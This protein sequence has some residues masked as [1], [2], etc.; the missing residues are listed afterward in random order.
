MALTETQKN[1]IRAGVVADWNA[2]APFGVPFRSY[3]RY[4]YEKLRL[5]WGTKERLVASGEGKLVGT[6]G[7]ETVAQGQATVE[8]HLSEQIVRQVSVGR[9]ANVKSL[10]LYLGRVSDE[11]TLTLPVNGTQVVATRKDNQSFGPEAQ[12]GR[13]LKVSVRETLPTSTG[14][15]VVTA[16][17]TGD[18]ALL[19]GQPEET[20]KQPA[21]P[22]A[23]L[24]Y[25]T[26]TEFDVGQGTAAM[27]TYTG[28]G[29]MRLTDTAANFGS[30]GMALRQG[31]YVELIG[32]PATSVSAVDQAAGWFYV[33]AVGVQQLQLRTVKYDR[34]AEG[35]F[36]ASTGTQPSNLND[37]F[38]YR[39]VRVESDLFT[40]ANPADAMAYAEPGDWVRARYN[41]GA[42][43]VL[44]TYKVKRRIQA[45]LIE[46][47]RDIYSG[48]QAPYTDTNADENTYVS[49]VAEYSVAK[50]TPDVMTYL[51]IT[52]PA[53]QFMTDGMVAD[54]YVLLKARTAV[55]DPSTQQ[56]KGAYPF[57]YRI[58]SV[59]QTQLTLLP[60]KH[61]LQNGKFVSV[62]SFYN[63]INDPVSYELYKTSTAYPV[64]LDGVKQRFY[65]ILSVGANGAVLN[66]KSGTKVEK[67]AADPADV[68]LGFA[69]TELEDAG[70]AIPAT[71]TE[72]VDA[73]IVRLVTDDNGRLLLVDQAA[74]F[75]QQ[76]TVGDMLDA[77]KR[78]GETQS[79]EAPGLYRINEIASPR[80]VF[81]ERARYGGPLAAPN[82]KEPPYTRKTGDAVQGYFATNP[83]NYLVKRQLLA[84]GQ[85]V[86]ER[87]Q[88]T[89]PV[90]TVAQV[91]DW[92]HVDT[93]TD[94]ARGLWRVEAVNL[95]ATN[96]VILTL[97]RDK[98][99]HNAD[100]GII[101]LAADSFPAEPF[102]ET[103]LDI[104]L[105]R[106][107]PYIEQLD[108]LVASLPESPIPWEPTVDGFA[109]RDMLKVTWAY[110]P[111]GAAEPET[112]TDYFAIS[113]YANNL[114]SLDLVPYSGA[115]GVYVRG[116]DT[117]ATG[118]AHHNASC[119]IIRVVDTLEEAQVALD[120]LVEL[121]DTA[122]T[123][124]IQDF[125]TMDQV[126]TDLIPAADNGF[127]DINVMYG[128]LAEALALTVGYKDDEH[129]VWGIDPKVTVK[130]SV[131]LAAMPPKHPT[132]ATADWRLAM[133]T[134]HF[135]QC[136]MLLASYDFR[137]IM[138]GK[139]YKE[140]KDIY[141]DVVLRSRGYEALTQATPTGVP[142]SSLASQVTE[143]LAA[144]TMTNRLRQAAEQ[145]LIARE[146]PDLVTSFDQLIDRHVD[147]AFEALT[148]NGELMANPY[149]VFVRD[150]QPQGPKPLVFNI[151]GLSIGRFYD[152]S[153]AAKR[154]AIKG[155]VGVPPD[156]TVRS[157]QRSYAL[158]RNAQRHYEDWAA[159]AQQ[160]A[161]AAT[162]P[163][164]QA[165]LAAWASRFLATAAIAEGKATNDG[166]QL[167][168]QKQA[169]LE[170][171]ENIIPD[172]AK[173]LFDNLAQLVEPASAAIE[174]S[175]EF[176]S[177]VETD[178]APTVITSGT[179]LAAGGVASEDAKLPA[180]ASF[181]GSGITNRFSNDVHDFRKTHVVQP[182]YMLQND[183][184]EDRELLSY[185]FRVSDSNS[186]I[187]GFELSKSGTLDSGPFNH[188][189]M[190][191]VQETYG[192]KYQVMDTLSRGWVAF[193]FGAQPEIWSVSGV[194]INDV[195]S[196]QATKMRE[197]Y[198]S[199][200]RI[201]MLA[202]RGEKL[203][204]AI[205][206]SGLLVY[207]YGVG[208]TMATDASSNEAVVPFTLQ[209][210]VAHV[211]FV[212]LIQHSQKFPAAVA[213]AGLIDGSPAGGGG[214]KFERPKS[215]A[216][217]PADPL[218]RPPAR[219]PVLNLDKAIPLKAPI[220]PKPN[221]GDA[222]PNTGV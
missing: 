105:V 87:V 196:D 92:L 43:V 187:K 133:A 62:G 126:L 210:L 214:L 211:Y 68:A 94:S 90:G 140:L 163:D 3:G 5:E 51:R 53:G 193:A 145:A 192:E 15:Q 37:P 144:R 110:W 194:L 142:A 82:D 149:Q 33:E 148:V 12:V 101:S 186:E 217:N 26:K 208:L 16:G 166:E 200:L 180:V 40:L 159:H 216:G 150:M 165:Q 156:R 96:K 56:A 116:G 115:D 112:R 86:Y 31:D 61:T 72:I 28:T 69:A 125:N 209:F 11:V 83:C 195:L 91:D 132:P 131:L 44:R 203:A 30:G 222:I 81:L 153:A 218:N 179:S 189:M 13:F 8:S 70:S 6:L 108:L 19:E 23:A 172:D 204:I 35:Q 71:F 50:A 89:L 134:H 124:T 171:A 47:E 17:A 202:K 10:A 21:T 57:A 151:P 207:G 76:V 48:I 199:Y 59:T 104:R 85:P 79:N 190:T 66:L 128:A 60:I 77:A 114:I 93:G 220:L 168:A 174:L 138:L 88:A 54:D 123:D 205:P 191:G 100:T 95:D 146:R 167:S 183:V 135:Q 9:M 182:L 107:E 219:S 99:N 184:L 75:D 45:G 176:V 49:R 162:K 109:L 34:Q 120:K 84:A 52:D 39:V 173:A 164:L 206:G 201:T 188:F 139:T 130:P 38:D 98:Y 143:A 129:E 58:A 161:G 185:M 106:P 157:K 55:L 181:S 113:D 213:T 122:S 27:I 177:A 212:P 103:G 137:S 147:T 154:E 119:Q 25:K 67:T 127:R 36:V 118:F 121:L 2:Q 215:T 1:A 111:L 152:T 18:Y 141:V 197:I 63:N 29:V 160:H 20:V 78:T 73:D 80:M 14:E 198:E 24:A 102:F 7:Y 74:A 221:L 64:E 175:E 46:L 97:R 178:A 158:N 155:M 32:T 42:T 136:V 41:E 117:F 4:V 170:F 169:A 65:E 22:N